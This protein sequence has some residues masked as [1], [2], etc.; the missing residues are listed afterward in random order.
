MVSVM[1][2]AEA[3]KTGLH[4]SEF[5]ECNCGAYLQASIATP[6]TT[7]HD[8]GSVLCKTVNKLYRPFTPIDTY[9][10]NI[11]LACSMADESPPS[12]RLYASCRLETHT[13]YSVYAVRHHLFLQPRQCHLNGGF[14]VLYASFD[15]ETL[16]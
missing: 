16:I 11:V 9:L 3:G 6:P 12:I 1:H 13:A 15:D 14:T 5:A 7:L 8:C 2:S 10:C 4:F